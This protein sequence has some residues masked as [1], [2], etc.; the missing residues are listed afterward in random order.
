VR[1]K[2]AI[3]LGNGLPDLVKPSEVLAAL[4]EAGFEILETQDD[5]SF[6]SLRL[7]HYQH[8]DLIYPCSEIASSF[9]LALA[10]LL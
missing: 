7:V 6:T 5:K 1:V 4:K 8:P 2:K 3:E 10:Y 9:L